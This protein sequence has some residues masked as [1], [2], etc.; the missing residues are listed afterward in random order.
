MLLASCMFSFAFVFSCYCTCSDRLFNFTGVCSERAKRAA[1]SV[2]AAISEE[3][4]VLARSQVKKIAE[5]ET[6]C[7]NLKLKKES[8]ATGYRRLSEK[9]RMFVEKAK[10]E[11]AE[12]IETHAT[13]LLDVREIW[14]WKPVA[15]QSTVR[16]FAIGSVNFMKLWL[17]HLMRFTRGV[18][19]SL[20]RVRK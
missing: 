11:K 3:L 15:I 10:R 6:A 7:A 2:R 20:A 17:H 16:M 14:I 18:C 1:E 19:R 13:E 4:E 5:L 9:H 8:V 12:L